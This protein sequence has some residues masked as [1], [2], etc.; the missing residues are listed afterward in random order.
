MFDRNWEAHD[1]IKARNGW[2]ANSEFNGPLFV[3]RSLHELADLIEGPAPVQPEYVPPHPDTCDFA[4]KNFDLLRSV[5]ECLAA[6]QK[7]NAIKALRDCGTPR[8][9][10]RAAKELLE[11]LFPMNNRNY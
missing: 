2:V 5:S 7:I 6:G 11:G 10:L 3:A 1:V 9:S 4:I 8:L